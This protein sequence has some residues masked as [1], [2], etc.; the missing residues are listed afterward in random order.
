[1][2]KV[3]LLPALLLGLLLVFSV[4]MSI[5]AFAG[6]P[7]AAAVAPTIRTVDN[8]FVQKQFGDQFT[9]LPELA[10]TYG[11]LDGDGVEDVVIA[12][13]C[14]N[15]MLDQGEHDYKVID[16]YYDFF[17]YGDPKVTTT[18]AEPNPARRGLVVLIIHGSG[19]E[20]WRSTKPKAKYV[21]VNLPYR[22]ISVRK[23]HLKKR[24]IEA[25][26]IEE[27]G[28]NGDSSALFF[29]GKKFKYVPMGGN[30]GDNTSE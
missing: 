29:D 9:L 27:A 12:A 3:S 4:T 30:M 24:N 10:V 19:P 20:G 11:D 5:P 28:D 16:P 7:P 8:A 18:F 14:K 17:G 22:A 13:R 26:Y 15:P 25:V 21:I 23:M 1:M 6:T 2:R